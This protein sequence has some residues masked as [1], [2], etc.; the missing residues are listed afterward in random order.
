[1]DLIL[2]VRDDPPAKPSRQSEKSN[3]KKTEKK[4]GTENLAPTPSI[5]IP[6]TTPIV[7]GSHRIDL[8]NFLSAVKEPVKKSTSSQKSGLKDIP[9]QISDSPLHVKFTLRQADYEDFLRLGIPF[10]K[11]KFS[12][13]GK[14]SF[15]MYILY[16]CV[17]IIYVA[18]IYSLF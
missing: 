8:S 16:V 14:Q 12:E 2:A 11:G 1:M 18:F 3:A 6:S 10:K 4:K 9:S 7:P 13:S 5:A 15:C 17:H